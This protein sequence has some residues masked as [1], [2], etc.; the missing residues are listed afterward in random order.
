MWDTIGWIIVMFFALGWSFGMTKSYY[1]TPINLRIVIWWWLAIATVFFTKISVFHLFYLMPLAL[2]L[3][4]V[5]IAIPG[6][7][8]TIL[9]CLILF[10]LSYYFNS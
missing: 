9:Y 7:I 3:S 5:G 10:G 2:I 4:L 8:L 1:A 6:I